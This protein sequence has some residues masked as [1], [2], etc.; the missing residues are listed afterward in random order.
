[1]KKV[2]QGFTLIELMIV[3][4][5]I[6][7]LASIAIPAYQDYTARAQVSEAINLMGGA[8]TPTAEMLAQGALTASTALDTVVGATSGRYVSGMHMN[9]NVPATGSPT[10]IYTVQFGSES[11]PDLR[12]KWLQMGYD[13]NQWWCGPTLDSARKSGG[14]GFTISAT[15]AIDANHAPAACR[16]SDADWSV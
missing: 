10:V 3:V 9:V 15:E 14:V 8:K 12:N 2:Q 6:G 7:I 11:A 1:M 5:I 13:G 4:A 16:A